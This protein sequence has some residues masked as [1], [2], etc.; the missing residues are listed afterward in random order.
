[1]QRW[2]NKI[3]KYHK[4]RKKTI[5]MEIYS[6]LL[7]YKLLTFI[8]ILMGI[9]PAVYGRCRNGYAD[10]DPESKYC[11]FIPYLKNNQSND[12]QHP[13]AGKSQT[14]AESFCKTLG[15]G[16][17]AYFES[18]TELIKLLNYFQSHYVIRDMFRDRTVVRGVYFPDNSSLCPE[19]PIGCALWYFGLK[20]DTSTNIYRYSSC[21]VNHFS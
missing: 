1:M 10:I 12:N 2:K 16:T 4:A 13:D 11:Y 17:L 21:K 3:T 9:S 14:E 5:L 18:E 15:G 19:P 7:N 6:Q 8:L 20:K